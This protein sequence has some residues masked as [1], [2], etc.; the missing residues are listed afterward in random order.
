LKT[1][2]EANEATLSKYKQFLIAFHFKL[3]P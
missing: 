2:E 3:Q 1:T